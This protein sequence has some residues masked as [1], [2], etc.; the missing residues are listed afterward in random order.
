MVRNI[1]KKIEITLD[2]KPLK[3]PEE[4]QIKIKEFWDETI[5]KE[6]YIWDGD[7]VCA[8]KLEETENKLI[9]TCKKTKYSHY[10]YDERIGIEN[11]NYWCSGLWAGILLKTCDG[12]Y[13]LG[14]EDE[15]TSIPHCV[16]TFGGGPDKEDITNNKIDIVNTIKR[17]LKEEINIDLDNKKEIL[18]W[19][20][21]FLEIPHNKRH[22][23]GIIAVGIL[24]MNKEEM[25][26]HHNEFIKL[27][28]ERNEEIEVKNLV[29]LN[30]NNALEELNKLQNPI[31]EYLKEIL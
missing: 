23:Y 26:A 9:L 15:Q 19:E 7:F 18:N 31:R 30:T 8:S 17:E 10:L 3:L 13:V 20:I 25:K 21:K 4:L 29:F 12:Y 28:Q 16:Q 1:N 11:Q 2:E 22:A 6:P 24:C 14:E 27:L 5:V